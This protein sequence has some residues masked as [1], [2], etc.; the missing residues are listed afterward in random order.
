MLRMLST[1][2]L[3][4]LVRSS[5]AENPSECNII[6]KKCGDSTQKSGAASAPLVMR[7]GRGG[8]VNSEQILVAAIEQHNSLTFKSLL[9]SGFTADEN[10]LLP[11]AVSNQKHDIARILLKRCADPN[12]VLD[13]SGSSPLSIAVKNKDLEM[14]SLL[15]E[16][17]ADPTLASVNGETPF[18]RA[19]REG[20]T[21]L[22]LLFLKHMIERKAIV[23][24]FP[25]NNV[26]SASVITG[27]NV[28]IHASQGRLK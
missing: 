18:G 2:F 22:V 13:S 10:L 27:G 16:Y 23:D 11:V 5:N 20:Q 17:G 7:A 14:A 3:F 12:F 1:F 24:N 25:N 6:P 4:F 8:A 26:I 19:E 21:E 15:L 9:K 28:N